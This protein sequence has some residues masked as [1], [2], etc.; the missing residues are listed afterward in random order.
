VLAMTVI[1]IS[2]MGHRMGQ[3]HSNPRELQQR[4]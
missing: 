3:R 4:L 2:D 1:N